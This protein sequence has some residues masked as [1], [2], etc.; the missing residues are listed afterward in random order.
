MNNIATLEVFWKY[1]Y[2][3]FYTIRL[4]KDNRKDELSETD[5]FYEIHDDPNHSHFNEFDVIAKII[6]GIGGLKKGAESRLFRFEDAAHALPP[7]VKDAGQV[8]DIEVIV[9]SELRLYCIRLTNEAVI[10]LNGAVK[11]KEAALDCPNV[12]SHFRLAQSVAKAIDKLLG[13]HDI[14]VEN[15]VI[16]NSSE[17]KEIILYL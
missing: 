12:K 7:K 9:D 5:K 8:L 4:E 1:P 17:E 11:T 3:T 2:V 6:D 15:G 14:R 16:I 13:D 10:L